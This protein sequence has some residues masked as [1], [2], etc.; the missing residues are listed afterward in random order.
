LRFFCEAFKGTPGAPTR[1]GQISSIRLL[2]LFD[3]YCER[4]FSQIA[5][6]LRLY[7]ADEIFDFVKAM[8]RLMLT[9]N[10]RS[11]SVDAI[12]H[13]AMT[14]YREESIR[15]VD[16]KYIQILDE[17][18]MLEQKP[19]GTQM[20]LFVSFVYE[21]FMEY[22]I[23]KAIL[24]ELL[25]T[26]RNITSQGVIS[27]AQGLLNS[28]GVFVPVIGVVFYLG[29]LLA[30]ENRDEGLDFVDWL[31]RSRRQD[32]ACRIISQWSPNYDRAFLRLINL[33][34]SG[35][36]STKKIA[37]DVMERISLGYWDQYYA[38]ISHLKLSKTLTAMVVYTEISNAGG[39]VTA[40]QRLDSVN[41]IAKTMQGPYGDFRHGLRTIKKIIYE[42]RDVLSAA[43]MEE[44]E[45]RLRKV[46]IGVL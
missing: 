23:A 10:S 6:R 26:L 9:S 42:S 22:T 43:Q 29:C 39:G 7:S 11:L 21:E 45:E 34:M 28:E 41:W 2:N 15:K 27:E 31:I 33:H 20:D 38:Y 1:I 5:E 4:K 25:M 36:R 3:K 24:S 44:A 8:G 14:E 46:N 19:A 37:W 16:S 32:I 30:R 17:D 12:R 13:L 35:D 18:I 40:K